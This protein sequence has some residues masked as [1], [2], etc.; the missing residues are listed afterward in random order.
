MVLLY[1]VHSVK[2]KMG[3]MGKKAY[4]VI[5]LAVGLLAAPCVSYAALPLITDDIGITETGKYELEIGNDNCRTEH[6]L[7]ADVY[8]SLKH[9]ISERMDF[10]VCLP[11]QVT[12]EVNNRIGCIALY[13][14]F[15]LIKN[16]FAVTVSNEYGTREYFL[17]AVLSHK[18]AEVS[19]HLNVGYETSGEADVSGNP[20]VSSAFEYPLKKIDFVGEII[21]EKAVSPAWQLGMRYKLDDITFFS[22]GFND[23]FRSAKAILSFG[24]H[25]AF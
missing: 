25:T 7:E 16:I 8:V 13:G 20:V 19:V 3:R 4:G 2:R 11:F 9:G 22:V 18:F 24:F 6:G 17:N 15:N 12:P 21:L 10:G 5:L 1:I 23:I 14:K